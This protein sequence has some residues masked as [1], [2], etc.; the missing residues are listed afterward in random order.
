MCC[1]FQ[2]TMKLLTSILM[3]V[4]VDLISGSPLDTT[5]YWNTP[6]QFCGSALSVQM[7]IICRGWY[8]EKAPTPKRLHQ[9]IKRGIVDDCCKIPCT[10]RFVKHYY[11]AT[12]PKQY[13]SLF[14]TLINY[15]IKPTYLLPIDKIILDTRN[16][17]KKCQ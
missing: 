1:M 8:N 2:I 13:V 4:C 5:A 3:L 17:F 9:L 12:P 16:P 14:G 7:A 15:S 10:R 6:I 11:C